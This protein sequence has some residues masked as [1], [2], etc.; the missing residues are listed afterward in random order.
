MRS[1]VCTS[2]P[3]ALLLVVAGPLHGR[4]GGGRLQSFEDVQWETYRHESPDFSL[5][6][7]YAYHGVESPGPGQ[8]FSAAEA[9]RVPSISVA[10]LPRPA[11]LEFDASAAAAAQ[12]ISPEGKVSGERTVDLGGVPA[13]VANV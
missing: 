2:L 10:L 11:T 5:Q 8:I 4:G 7:P 1:K 13:R 9:L 3:V 12:R 6:Y